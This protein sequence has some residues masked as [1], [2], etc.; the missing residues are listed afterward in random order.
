MF[1]FS[2]PIFHFSN[3]PTFLSTIMVFTMN[4]NIWL[5]E[6]IF[7]VVDF[8]YEKMPQPVPDRKHLKQCKIISHRGEHDNRSIF[9]NTI[10]AFDRVNKAGVW[11][12][13][14]DVRWTKDLMPVVF[15]DAGL[16]RVFGSD[17]NIDQ[18]TLTELNMHCRLIPALSEVI[19]KYGKKMHLMVEIKKEVYP[20]PEHQNNVLKD[21]FRCLT[22]QDDFHFISLRPEMF[23]L[24]DFVPS[25]TFVPS[26]RFNVKQLSDL[27]I[28]NNYRGIAGHYVLITD[29]LLKKHHLQKQCVGTG[30]ICSQN[31]LFR[32]LNRGVE[33][34]FTNHAL[35]LQSICDSL[36]AAFA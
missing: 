4:I 1:R 27:A 36:L 20:N 33:W 9:E 10:A 17:I 23:M 6:R 19:Q 5:E 26:A 22:P 7:K 12:I 13:E 8:V 15:H 32:E 24:I 14:L 25:S 16:Q 31:C 29:T 18:M 11:G 35:K 34:I 2:C 3:I 28:T 21:L 30:Y